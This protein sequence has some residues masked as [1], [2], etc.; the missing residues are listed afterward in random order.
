[1]IRDLDACRIGWELIDIARHSYWGGH[2]AVILQVSRGCPHL[3]T[4]C[5]QRGFRTQWRHRDPVKLASGIGW[6]NRTPGVTLDTLADENP[7]T[8]PKAGQAFL[9][10]MIAEAVPVTIIGSTRADDIGRDA[11][12]LHLDKK[13]GCL[14][15]LM[16][17]GGTDEATLGTLEKRRN[18]AQGSRGHPVAAPARHDRPVHIRRGVRG[19]NR[20]RFCAPLAPP[21]AP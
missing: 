3:C 8:S 16:G 7:T 15:F 9:H 6:L 19:G 4:C 17:I 1:M 12:I 2:R 5:G 20:L 11:D 18:P 10:A 14:R 21:A 13:A